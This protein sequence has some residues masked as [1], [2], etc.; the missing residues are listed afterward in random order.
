MESMQSL[1]LLPRGLGEGGG[2]K[3][4][5]PPEYQLIPPPLPPKPPTAARQPVAPEP[6]VRIQT[7]HHTF[8]LQRDRV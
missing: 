5:L 6:E 7:V 4:G 8:C 2:E 1:Q 3:T